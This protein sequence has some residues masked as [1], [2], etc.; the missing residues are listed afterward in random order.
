M[1]LQKKMNIAILGF[2]VVF[3]LISNKN[4]SQE[5]ILNT[6]KSSLIV[7]GTSNV[8]DWEI[9]TENQK[10]SIS[11]DATSKIQIQNL[12]IVV[13]AE[14]LKSG[15]R[16]MDKNTY[17]ALNTDKYKT[18]EFQFVSTDAITDVG[19]GTFKVKSKGDL[20]ISGVTKRISLDF[21]L[22]Q[23]NDTVNL[24]GEK[25]IKMTDYGIEP[26]KA[27]FGTIK[28]GDEITIKFNTILQK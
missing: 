11:L 21:T 8:H 10:G 19:N 25:T 18:I 6:Q 4:Y 14:S 23:V 20:T 16:G 22:N 13:Q 17:K 9:E 24:A 5:Y 2:S 15:K 3:L 28:T 12:K 1:F 7:L 27:L 26:P